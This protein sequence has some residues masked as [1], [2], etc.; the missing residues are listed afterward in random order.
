MIETMWIILGSTLICSSPIFGYP[1]LDE[2]IIITL[3]NDTCLRTVQI[4]TAA[5]EVKPGE[6]LYRIILA[7]ECEKVGHDWEG[8][9]YE[10]DDWQYCKT[11][12]QRRHKITKEEWIY[13]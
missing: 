6:T 2:K 8:L 9:Y 7:T 13:E 12:A 10:E 5:P 3:K 11:C 1:I 4:S